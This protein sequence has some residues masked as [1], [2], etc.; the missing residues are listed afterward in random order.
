M[1]LKPNSKFN[2]NY[3]AWRDLISK[4][5]LSHLYSELRISSVDIARVTGVEQASIYKCLIRY[6]IPTRSVGQRTYGATG[7]LNPRWKGDKVGYCAAHDRLRRLSQAPDKCSKCS[8]PVSSPHSHQWANL[9][10]KFHDPSDYL[11]LCSS[12]H[13]MMDLAAE[14]KAHMESGR[15]V[16]DSAGIRKYLLGATRMYRLQ[17]DILAD[18]GWSLAGV[19]KPKGGKM[20]FVYMQHPKYSTGDK[21]Y[22]TKNAALKIARSDRASEGKYRARSSRFRNS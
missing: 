22:Y 4:E 11:W 19:Y 7:R 20:A 3:R 2:P 1:P 13:R 8:K 5:Y 18:Y 17:F 9:T 10:G 21:P 6:G 16:T 15:C 14:A 12:C